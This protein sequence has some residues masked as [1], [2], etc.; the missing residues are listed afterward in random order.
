ME[1]RLQNKDSQMTITKERE[2]VK[3]TLLSKDCE[4]EI[5]VQIESQR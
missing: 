5:E 1:Q 2:I 4:R 3:E